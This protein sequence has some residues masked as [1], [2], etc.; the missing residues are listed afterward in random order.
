MCKGLNLKDTSVIVNAG[1]PTP[2]VKYLTCSP[3]EFQCRSGECIDNSR[4]CDGQRD[5]S[6]ETD[7][8]DCGKLQ[9]LPCTI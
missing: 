3:L 8:L 1:R 7:E 2:P 6:D 9:V 5:C 4:R